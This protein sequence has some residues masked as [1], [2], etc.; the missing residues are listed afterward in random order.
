MM[1]SRLS[2]QRTIITL[3]Q[4]AIILAEVYNPNSLLGLHLQRQLILKSNNTITGIIRFPAFGIID[5]N[6]DL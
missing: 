4:I 5:N 3:S 2:K 6:I 1:V